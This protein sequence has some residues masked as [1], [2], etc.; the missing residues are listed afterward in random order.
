MLEFFC[1]WFCEGVLGC[2]DASARQQKLGAPGWL[3]TALLENTSF[4][5]LFGPGGR[6]LSLLRLKEGGTGAI[7]PPTSGTRTLATLWP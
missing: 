6:S 7:G 3:S 2:Y 5:D 4:G 1:V